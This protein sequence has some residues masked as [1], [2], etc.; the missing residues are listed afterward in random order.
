MDGGSSSWSWVKCVDVGE[1][2]AVAALVEGGGEGLEKGGG[3]K[4]NI[5]GGVE[6]ETERTCGVFQWRVME[7][8]DVRPGTSNVNR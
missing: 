8:R 3:G 2:V 6:P 5:E 1:V 4:E 7:A